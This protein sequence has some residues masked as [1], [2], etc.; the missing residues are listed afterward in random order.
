MTNHPPAIRPEHA[1]PRAGW[2]ATVCACGL[3]L[4]AMLAAGCG[5]TQSRLQNSDGVR[6]YQQSHYQAALQRFQ[7]ALQAEPEN[8]DSYYN[9]AATHHQ[10]GKA[11]QQQA[12]LDRA[13]NYY[14]QCLDYADKKNVEHRDCYRGLAVLLMDEGRSEQAF[15]LLE[16]WSAKYPTS[17]EAKIELA[18]LYDEHGNLEQAKGHL[19]QALVNQPNNPRA[20]AALGK[21][22]EELG[23]H[24]QALA[25]YQR[26]L[27]NDRFQPQVASRVQTLQNALG[28]APAALTPP[29]TAGNRARSI[30]AS[31]LSSTLR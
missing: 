3:L 19:M 22:R 1:A 7:Q 11:N 16:G 30:D 28:Q 2:N 5:Q 29:A 15:T 4:A 24:S 23:E 18:R 8:P 12:D 6:L 25:D 13:E 14:N 27:Y 10:L 17:A 26:S 20:L 9:L 21:V 31:P